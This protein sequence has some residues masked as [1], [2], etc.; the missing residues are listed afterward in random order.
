MDHT[1][2]LRT[3]YVFRL[4]LSHSRKGYTEAVTRLATECL[5]R[6]LENA[7]R[8]FGRRAKS[9]GLGTIRH[10]SPADDSNGER[11]QDHPA[12]QVGCDLAH[13]RTR[14]SPW[15]SPRASV[16]SP[17]I[18]PPK[19][20]CWRDGLVMHGQPQWPRGSGLHPF[21]IFERPEQAQ[22]ATSTQTPCSK[23]LA[24]PARR[25]SFE[26]ALFWL[27]SCGCSEFRW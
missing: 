6:F 2:K 4:V 27:R 25:A 5:I 17:T 26:V 11:R 18:S 8:A 7:F 3:T 1:D 22:L 9:G 10:R 12:T 19:N 20:P 15:Q 13:H 23:W 16:A 14:S 21:G 24:V